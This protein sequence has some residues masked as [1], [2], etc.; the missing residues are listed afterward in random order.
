MDNEKTR[1]LIE[2]YPTIFP[3]NDKFY[4]ECG[5]GWYDLL[6][7]LC[8]SIQSHINRIVSSESSQIAVLQIKEKFGGLRFYANGGDEITDAY[9][10][11][12][13]R[14][15]YKICEQCGKPGKPSKSGWIKTACEE[16]TK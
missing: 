1:S 9:V 14:M 2:K 6:D 13:E 4:I 12:A 8:S 10:Y 5:N 15:S 3:A 11:L 7:V 16:H